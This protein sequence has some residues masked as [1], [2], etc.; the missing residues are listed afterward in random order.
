MAS[1]QKIQE[2]YKVA[3]SSGFFKDLKTEDLLIAC[4][5]YQQNSDQEIDI[6]IKNMQNTQQKQFA[7]KAKKELKRKDF[8]R[9]KLAETN[10]RKLE[11]QKADELLKK[12]MED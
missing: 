11:L 4:Q 5:S 2:L 10:D 6:A 3:L 12:L 7:L 1:E 9:N 8:A